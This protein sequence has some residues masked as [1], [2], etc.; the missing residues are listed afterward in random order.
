MTSE[1]RRNFLMAAAPGAAAL[2]ML[3][4]TPAQAALAA[5]AKALHV[6]DFGAEGD[7][8]T[9][10]GDAFQRALDTAEDAG[11]GVVHIPPG[12]YLLD[13]TPFVGTRVHLMGSGP[14]TVLRGV[15]PEGEEG[16]AL[17]SNK[18]QHAPRYDGAHD[19]SI[20]H[21]AIDSPA[22][23]GIVITHAARVYIGF[24]HGIDVYNHF[25]DTV[26]RDILCENL[27]LT[28]RSGTS[29][30]QIDSIHGAQTTWDGEQAVAPLRDGTD[31]EDLIL[32]NSIITAVA[33]HEGGRP[34]HD[35]SIHFHG[36]EAKGFNFSDLI[37]GGAATG[38]YQ[39]ANTSY[40]DIQI[41][42]VRSTNP[43]RAIWLNPGRTGQRNLMIRGLQHTPESN[44]AG[45]SIEI[46]GR[47]GLIISDC[48]LEVPG[49]CAA[50]IEIAASQRI[51]IH[52]VQ[53]RGEGGTGIL[54]DESEAEI[55][56]CHLD[57]FGKK[58]GQ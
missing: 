22:T 40:R 54:L 7:G 25:V 29:T 56:A 2:G 14:A 3:A 26:G 20:S 58:W 4:T 27:F 5:G 9:H 24:I 11:G 31:T 21:L 37:L 53:A 38:F 44:E 10:C 12:T 33:G 23:N 6:T 17:I 52:G 51:T 34:Q 36:S 30:F 15:R 16:A 39:D 46:H 43:G 41:N 55:H 32:R 48:Q 19:W 28:G 35:A 1:S 47:D 8:D 49:E 45:K 18:G 57:G 42:N 13:K 50:A